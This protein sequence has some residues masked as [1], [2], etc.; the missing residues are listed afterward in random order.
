M[1]TLIAVGGSA[2]L[3]ASRR[4]CLAWF[5]KAR[6]A[7]HNTGMEEMDV[8]ATSV[9]PDNKTGFWF[10]YNSNFL[11]KGSTSGGHARFIT[12]RYTK[13]ILLTLNGH[14]HEVRTLKAA[15]AALGGPDRS[16]R[17]MH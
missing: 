10:T 6:V 14:K 17:C 4:P 15:D 13:K 9:R 12:L 11:E 1:V 7:S 5:G 3:P 2:V 8:M 16:V